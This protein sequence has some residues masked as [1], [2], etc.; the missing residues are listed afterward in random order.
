MIF[1]FHITS[2]PPPMSYSIF[3]SI[4]C[5]H[6]LLTHSI[7]HNARCL[8]MNTCHTNEISSYI[9]KLMNVHMQ[10]PSDLFVHTEITADVLRHRQHRVRFSSSK[11]DETE[12]IFLNFKCLRDVF[13]PQCKTIYVD[14]YLS[15]IARSQSLISWNTC[16]LTSFYS[17]MKVGQANSQ[18][19]KSGTYSSLA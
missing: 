1:N 18:S 11:N 4:I 3:A 7:H 6:N 12:F 9:H 5:T 14:L 8:I 19:V 13:C 10:A 16:P 2:P 15:L 17:C